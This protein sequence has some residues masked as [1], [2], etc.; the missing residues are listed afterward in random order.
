[1]S[2]KSLPL[3]WLLHIMHFMDFCLIHIK[4]DS[5][6]IMSVYMLAY[7]FYQ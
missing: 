6:S 2:Y 4:A 1:M 7:A 5:V 3:R